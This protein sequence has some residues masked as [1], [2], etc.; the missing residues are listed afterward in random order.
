VSDWLVTTRSPSL[1]SNA[2]A[3]LP[4]SASSNTSVNR[5]NAGSPALAVIM[6]ACLPAPTAKN[7]SSSNRRSS[8]SG[9]SRIELPSTSLNLS[10][11]S[12]HA[13]QMIVTCRG[14]WNCRTRCNPDTLIASVQRDCQLVSI[15][16]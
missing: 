8:S 15:R 10:A 11:N 16:Q 12:W 6:Y 14:P 5:Q 4:A 9:R 7:W 1:V 2:D 13:S 3:S